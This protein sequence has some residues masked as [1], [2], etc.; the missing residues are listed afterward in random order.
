MA[1]GQAIHHIES[2]GSNEITNP[3]VQNRLNKTNNLIN[4]SIKT[5]FHFFAYF[6]AHSNSKKN[7]D[8]GRYF[9]KIGG[10]L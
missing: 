10:S 9:Q 7:Y 6:C 4:A 1:V 5:V 2:G 3:A 8:T